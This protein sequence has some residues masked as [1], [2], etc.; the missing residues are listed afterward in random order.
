MRSLFN[1]RPS[2]GGRSACVEPTSIDREARPPSPYLHG[3]RSRGLPGLPLP[4][5]R[6]RPARSLPART[7]REGPRRSRCRPGTASAEGPRLTL[8]SFRAGE[9]QPGP[10]RSQGAPCRPR[11]KGP[12]RGGGLGWPGAS[13]KAPGGGSGAGLLPRAGNAPVALQAVL[14]AQRKGEDVETSKKCRCRRRAGGRAEGAL[15]NETG[16]APSR[17]GGGQ[18]GRGPSEARPLPQPPPPPLLPP[19]GPQGRTSSTRSPRTRPS[20][21]GRPR[22]CTTTG[23]RWR[24]AR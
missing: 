22:S 3:L 16:P 17:E 24:W 13:P 8:P 19:Q 20:W 5:G 6:A 10:P 11:K 4:I 15:V 21:T 12:L 14:A 2:P 9:Q 7:R 23:S 1:P 18:A